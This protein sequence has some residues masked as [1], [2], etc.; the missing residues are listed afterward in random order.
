MVPWLVR[1]AWPVGQNGLTVR[2]SLRGD[3]TVVI[4]RVAA[5]LR[6]PMVAA[7]LDFIEADVRH[8]PQRVRVIPVDVFDRARALS[9]GVE[10]DL[11][12]P[13]DADEG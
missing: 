6:D 1:G 8:H 10:V 2:F 5:A 7:F 13:L 9:V 11:D 12:A 3:D 4:T